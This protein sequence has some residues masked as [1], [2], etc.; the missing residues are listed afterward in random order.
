VSP[1]GIPPPT[2]A[3]SHLRRFGD[4]FVVAYLLA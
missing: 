1:Q 3:L 2:A 4:D